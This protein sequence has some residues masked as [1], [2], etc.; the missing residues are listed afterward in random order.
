MIHRTIIKILKKI[1]PNRRGG[2]IDERFLEK[3][4]KQHVKTIFEV[5]ARFGDES[6]NLSNAYT[7]AAI[8][9][10][11]PNPLTHKQCEK[12]LVG[13]K[14]I[15]FYK[16]ALGS[17]EKIQIFHPYLV[18]NNPGASSFLKRIDFEK[19]QHLD[20]LEVQIRAAKNVMQE[21][22][23]VEV[24]L[25][26]MDVQGF[27]LEVLKGFGDCLRKIQYIIMEE[28]AKKPSERYLEKGLHSKYI[29]APSQDEIKQYMNKNDFFELVRLK[30][31]K[32][33]D[34]VL[35]EQSMR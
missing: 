21:L 35:Y 3:I 11:D 17:E 6:I 5:G 4:N 12:N 32:I 22:G 25:L 28:P 24:S 9:C 13:F 2:Y 16:Y 33:E 27:E 34:N 19:T 18:N 14:N 31:N 23:L 8:Y 30:E 26:C 1:Y 20:G 7:N 15:N 10:F 29:G